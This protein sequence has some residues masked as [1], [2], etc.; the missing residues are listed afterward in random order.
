MLT[1]AADRSVPDKLDWWH[2]ADK[3]SSEQDSVQ[4]QCHTRQNAKCPL[5]TYAPDLEETYGEGID[6][7]NTGLKTGIMIFFTHEMLRSLK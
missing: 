1:G 2:K 3:L 6:M 5:L 7:E 4:A